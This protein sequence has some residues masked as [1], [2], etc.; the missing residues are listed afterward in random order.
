MTEL[1]YDIRILVRQ[2]K[3]EWNGLIASGELLLKMKLLLL[4][5]VMKSFFEYPYFC[6]ESMCHDSLA[7]GTHSK[8]AQI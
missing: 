7:F 8:N 6:L 3:E 4:N 2:E 5:L 1:N